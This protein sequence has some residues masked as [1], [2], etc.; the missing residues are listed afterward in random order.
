MRIVEELMEIW[1]NEVC[2]RPSRE[3]LE[4]YLGPFKV[5]GKPSAHSYQIKLP[6]HLCTI[7]SVF[8]IS[9][10]EPATPVKSQIIEIC[11][12]TYYH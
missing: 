8:H 6:H 4:R 3:L 5:T 11:L 12:P 7:Y 1:L 9:Q 2:D 10:L